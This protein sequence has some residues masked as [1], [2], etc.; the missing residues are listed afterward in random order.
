VLVPDSRNRARS[1]SAYG[2]TALRAVI[3]LAAVLAGILY[4][5]HILGTIYRPYDDE[6]YL[7]LA[8]D[9]YLRGGHLFTDVFSQYGPFYF[10]ALGALFGLLHLPV[11]H[12]AGRLVTLLC[13]Q[14]SAWSGGY[15]VYKVTRDIVL[16]AAAA[17]ACTQLGSALA[18]EP[19]HPQQIILLILMLACFASLPRERRQLWSLLLGA[20]GAA[21]F[22][23]KINVGILFL[24][25][26]ACVLICSFPSGRLRT[27]GIALLLAY[28]VGFPLLL[29]REGLQGWGGRCCLIAVLCG[30]STV[31]AGALT[32]PG[33]QRPGR[34]LLCAA[35]GAL[36]GSAL[37]VLGTMLQGMPLATLLDGVVTAPLTQPKLFFLPLW[38]SNGEIVSA[39]LWSTGIAALYWFRDRWRS[40]AD[41]VDALRC[42][43]GFCAILLLAVNPKGIAW[44]LP[45]L[46]LG[47]MPV[48]GE[49]WSALDCYPRLFV[50]SLAATQFLQGYPVA[51]SQISVAAMPLLLWAAI[52]VHDGAGG[53]F[54][55]PLRVTKLAGGRFPK[56]SVLGGLIMFAL[57]VGMFSSGSLSWRYPY[58]ASRLRGAA[59][60]HLP[61]EEEERYESL[62]GNIA[63][64][65]D[66]LVTLPGMG[67]FNYWSGIPT[68]NG[69]NMTAWM[70]VFDRGRQ[71]R[72]LDLVRSDPRACSVYN[73]PR[74]SMWGAT[75][76]ELAA[77][78][79][80]RY[81]IDE[82]PKVTQIDDYEIRVTPGRNSPWTEA[83]PRRAR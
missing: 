71:Q 47:L 12:D 40:R 70:R 22:F 73:A 81:I 46:P 6:G 61:A 9:H 31:L 34:N 17:L 43:V 58:P 11:N 52:C 14:L 35:A 20:M 83:V 13:W 78:P 51:G 48:R 62:A 53:L 54:R 28:N 67:S 26:L 38:I 64:N 44:I 55:L 41:L 25:A 75:A 42:A 15:F 56:D 36:L 16:A 27:I 29:T 19:G 39:M 82:M 72:I 80:A 69:S 1:T 4:A 23:T 63:A 59:W 7:L 21:L 37:I 79:L 30:V 8:I 24:A 76:E 18:S 77:S 57:M 60:L 74:T 33:V 50:T 2:G 49:K 3:A 65:C 5:R 68:P 66:L 10:Y 32:M 45:S